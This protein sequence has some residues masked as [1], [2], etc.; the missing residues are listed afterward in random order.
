[1]YKLVIIALLFVSFSINGQTKTKTPN[2]KL[3][4]KSFYGVD[5][6]LLLKQ[7][8]DTINKLVSTNQRSVFCGFNIFNFDLPVIQKRLIV[9]GIELPDCLDTFGLKEW[10]IK[11]IID[12]AQIWKSTSWGMS[13]LINVATA[14]GIPSPKDTIDGSMTS[15]LFYADI[16]N[17]EDIK[18]YC[19]KD[20]LTTAN[21]YRRCIGADLLEVGWE[22]V[23][24]KQVPLVEKIF[25][26][27]KITEEDLQK[28]EEI[29]KDFN[30]EE[31]KIKKDI[32]NAAIIKK[33]TW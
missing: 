16:K 2:N 1:M 14:L 32:M 22:T 13:S 17:V 30:E 20:V 29:S 18:T 15:D 28:I 27:Q 19:E 10:N 5:E 7:F 12:L 33:R 31:S 4:L 24:A 21:V 8:S 6:E 26:T 11:N 23:K 25:N 3:Q 9:N